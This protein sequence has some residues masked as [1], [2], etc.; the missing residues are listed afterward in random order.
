MMK[1]TSGSSINQIAMELTRLMGFLERR[2][3]ARRGRKALGVSIQY[4]LT[5]MA[6]SIW[7]KRRDDNALIQNFP[8]VVMVVGFGRLNMPRTGCI[9]STQAQVARF[10]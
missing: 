4:I 9:G 6:K 10:T 3:T 7:R 5:A 2:G 8:T 1:N